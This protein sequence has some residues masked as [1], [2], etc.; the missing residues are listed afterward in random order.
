MGK[1]K[2]MRVA[3]L[4]GGQSEEHEISIMSA[5]NIVSA[6]DRNKYEVVLIGISRAGAWYLC[7]DDILHNVP[8]E[9]VPVDFTIEGARV[10]PVPG[11]DGCFFNIDENCR[12]DKVDVVFPVLHGT[13]GED[14]SV[15]GILKL[16]NLPFVGAGIAGSAIGMDK[17]VAKRLLRD[18]GLPVTDTIICLIEDKDE[19]EAELAVDLL[20]L[21]LFIKPANMGSSVGVIKVEDAGCF[22]DALDEAFKYDTKVLIEKSVAG[23]EIECALLGNEEVMVSVPGEIVPH[24]SFYSYEAKYIEKDGAEL[25]V[26]ADLPADVSETIRAMAISAYKVLCCYGMA[27]VDFFLQDDGSIFIN[28]INTIPGFTEISMYP[29]LWAQTGIDHTELVDR[30]ITL[31]LEQYE[32]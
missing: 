31:A 26:P 2:Q 11:D 25:C 20:G 7:D 16:A 22:K 12:L 29:R 14:G 13:C 27:R 6:I 19:C 17:D 8:E 1:N 23:R 30:L 24:T 18:A 10:T 5:K 32:K 9:G 3:V 4:F 15:Q 21:P 28:E